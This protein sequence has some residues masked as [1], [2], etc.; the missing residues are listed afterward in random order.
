MI[1][2]TVFRPIFPERERTGSTAS[3]PSNRSSTKYSR[4]ATILYPSFQNTSQKSIELR[5]N[6]PSPSRKASKSYQS[7]ATN[8]DRVHRRIL[9]LRGGERGKIDKQE[10][11]SNVRGPAGFHPRFSHCFCAR[12]EARGRIINSSPHSGRGEGTRESS[13]DPGDNDDHR[14]DRARRTTTWDVPPLPFSPPRTIVNYSARCHCYSPPPINGSSLPFLLFPFL[15]FFSFCFRSLLF[16]RTSSSIRFPSGYSLSLF[17]F[18][19]FSGSQID[20]WNNVVA[21]L[22]SY[23]SIDSRARDKRSTTCFIA[24]TPIPCQGVGDFLGNGRME[25]RDL[26]RFENDLRRIQHFR[27]V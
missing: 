23:R 11:S 1:R 20:L 10:W 18:V 24:L 12:R 17:F 2:Y 27:A 15:F 25:T 16:P 22:V 13:T 5:N 8:I 14:A 3:F 4:A 6:L 26:S 7:I 9:K 21:C 19:F